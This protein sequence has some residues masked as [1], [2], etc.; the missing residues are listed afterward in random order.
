MFSNVFIAI[1][2]ALIFRN[3]IIKQFKCDLGNKSC[4]LLRTV[5]LY[6]EIL[7]KEFFFFSGYNI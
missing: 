5:V 2:I 6:E 1:K 3:S 7:E 4:F